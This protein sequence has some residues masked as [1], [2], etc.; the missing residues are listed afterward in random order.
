MFHEVDLHGRFVDE[1]LEFG[2][3]YKTAI[4]ELRMAGEFFQQETAMPIAFE[5]AELARLLIQKGCEKVDKM[6]WNG[7]RCRGWQ[8]VRLAKQ[9]SR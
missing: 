4:E 8:G 9:E 2:P 6:S 5:T 7:K 3:E 1:R